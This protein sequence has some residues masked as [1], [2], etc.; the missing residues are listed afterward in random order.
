MNDMIYCNLI[1]L[2][3][4]AAVAKLVLPC[5]PRHT[6]V[7]SMLVMFIN[8]YINITIPFLPSAG[9]CITETTLWF[10]DMLHGQYMFHL[11]FH[12]SICPMFYFVNLFELGVRAATTTLKAMFL[13]AYLNMDDFCLVAWSLEWSGFRYWVSS[14]KHKGDTVVVLCHIHLV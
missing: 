4:I 2:Y 9:L 5:V 10:E 12:L 14:E 6:S 8:A 7:A 11:L 1:N 13:L 3:Q